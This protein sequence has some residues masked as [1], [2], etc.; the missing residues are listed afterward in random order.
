MF[1]NY[2]FPRFSIILQ[3]TSDFRAKTNLIRILTH[4]SENGSLL[5]V[6]TE[7]GHIIVHDIKTQKQQILSNR[8]EKVTAVKFLSGRLFSA[9]SG[10]VSKWTKDLGEVELEVKC[11]SKKEEVT[12][13]SELAG[14]LVAASKK[15]KLFEGK[16]L[17]HEWI[18]HSESVL[19]LDSST[20]GKYLVSYGQTSTVAVW[21]ENN[22][23]TECR[24]QI[25]GKLVHHLISILF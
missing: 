16:S 20:D 19:A 24:L 8:V 11:E 6:G 25:T 5:A 18:G 2:W 22:E 12:Q 4:N 15:I 13:I 7:S 10:K 21:T 9:Q 1:K 17:K 23:K 14:S 3:T